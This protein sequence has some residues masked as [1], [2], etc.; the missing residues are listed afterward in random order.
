MYGKKTLPIYKD[1]NR[2][3]KKFR[4][5][6]KPENIT[7]APHTIL[8]EYSE[9]VPQLLI[10]LWKSDGFGK[11]NNGLIEIINPKDFEPV[12]WTWLGKE[13]ENYVPFA[14]S[15][16]GEL[17]YYR[18]LT[19]TDE[20]V[21]IIDIQYRRIQTLTW[22]FDSFFEDFLIN[23]EDREMWLRE[24][25]FKQ[26]IAY[27]GLLEKNEVFIFT[28]I[29]AMGGAEETKYLTKGNAQV[30]QDIVFQMTS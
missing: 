9:K 23:E 12:L 25:L 21:C 14:I 22:D 7:P 27:Q 26:A 6:F 13:V 17:F 24:S 3:M 29:L 20:D 19:E 4:E 11:Y 8:E 1:F 18:K 15:G 10:E 5:T 28:P 2:I 16:F 30:Y